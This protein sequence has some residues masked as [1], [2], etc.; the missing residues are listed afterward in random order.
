MTC[1]ARPPA[2]SLGQAATPTTG[3]D[4]RAGD[5][6]AEINTEIDRRTAG[7]KETRVW[8][9]QEPVISLNWAL[10]RRWDQEMQERRL[11]EC[12]LTQLNGAAGKNPRAVQEF[13]RACNDDFSF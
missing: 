7:R 9:I 2:G 11:R 6:I 3:G 13:K 5:I 12:A 1:P 4:P 10:V 8:S